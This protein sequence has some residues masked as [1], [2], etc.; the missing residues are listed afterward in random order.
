MSQIQG[1][2]MSKKKVKYLERIIKILPYV[3][4]PKIIYMTREFNR[5]IKE[6]LQ[7]DEPELSGMKIIVLTP[8]YKKDEGRDDWDF[9]IRS[10]VDKNGN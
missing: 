1:E 10:G 9:Q 2:T 3:Y 5:K 6:E 4:N 7:K 8:I